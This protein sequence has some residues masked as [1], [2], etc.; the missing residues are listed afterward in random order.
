MIT[1]KFNLIPNDNRIFHQEGYDIDIL[2]TV[3]GIS[4]QNDCFVEFIVET[5]NATKIYLS[6]INYC[7]ET[8]RI[9]MSKES[10]QT[11]TTLIDFE[12]KNLYMTETNVLESED[13][14]IIKNSSLYL[15]VQKDLFNICLYNA[16]GKLL[17]DLENTDKKSW[18]VTPPMAYRSNLNDLTEQPVISFRMKND[19]HFYGLGEKFSPLDKRHTKATIWGAD[20]MGTNTT[21]LSYKSIP[22]LFSNYNY[23]VLFNTTYKSQFEIGTFS[24]PTAS[25]MVYEKCLDLFIWAKDN[26][27]EMLERYYRMVGKPYMIPKWALGI[28]MSKCSYNTNEELDQLTSMLQKKEIPI[29]CI[30]IDTGWMK[31][32]FYNTIGTDACDFVWDDEKL[33]DRKTL[34]KELKQ[35]GYHL[36][37]WINPYIAEHTDL[38]HEASQKGY[39]VKDQDGHN[40]R[41]ESGETAGLVDFTNPDA[42]RWWQS[43]LEVFI[44]DGMDCVKPDYADRTP[45]NA[46]FY[47]GKTGEEMHNI[48][49]YY[50][51]K[52]V[53]ELIY[54]KTNEHIMFRRSGYIG[55][56]KYPVTWAGDTQTSW[57]AL[58][59]VIRAG[60]SAGLC[61][62]VFWSHD[63]GGFTGPKPS[64]ELYVRWAQYAMF[65]PITRFHGTTPRE[66][67]NYGKEAEKIVVD[68]MRLRYR[69][70]PYIYHYA[71]KSCQNGLPMMRALVAEYSD[72]PFI[73]TIEDE[74]MFGDSLLVAPV[75]LPE[76]RSRNVYLPAGYWKAINGN[77]GIL[78]GNQYYKIDTPLERIPL[79]MKDGSI[80]VEYKNNIKNSLEHDGMYKLTIFC[81][82]KNAYLYLDD[83]E[84]AI[85]VNATLIDKNLDIMIKHNVKSL[86]IDVIND[87]FDAIIL[88]GQ[89]YQTYEKTFHIAL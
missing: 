34:F 8:F 19:E 45:C 44:D 87:H 85:E 41:I 66:P 38:Y 55:T 14:Y 70:L 84:Y 69:L 22:V 57:P 12:D 40:A 49:S 18:C 43:Q 5:Q 20:T 25:V 82:E 89:V 48:Y 64:D 36:C 80:L 71:Q 27:K 10:R 72:D 3:K 59:C 53:D 65:T 21:D 83:D 86:E 62:E 81:Y 54:K 76:V 13:K 46:V 88:N 16:Q 28:W 37:M 6:I 4:Y 24:Y 56:Q 31:E 75:I 7:E 26:F 58:K 61:G 23:G 35:K 51:V 78:L 79:F 50:Y 33:R 2:K 52:A 67:W 32:S 68:Y 63:A 74:Y 11:H 47:N 77:E 17:W 15:E 9:I 29:D 60:L 39:L 1:N 30:N 73:H 42:T